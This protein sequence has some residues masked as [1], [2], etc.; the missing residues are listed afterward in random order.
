M[1][2]R[3]PR[4][5][6]T[7]RKRAFLETEHFEQ[8][9]KELSP[10]LHKVASKISRPYYIDNS[11]LVQEALWHIFR[12]RDKYDER[13]SSIMTWSLRVAKN[14]F[15]NIA[16]NGFRD[17]RCPKDSDKKALNPIDYEDLLYVVD[18]GMP[19]CVTHSTVIEDIHE[20][21]LIEHARKR[22][23]GFAATLFE[24]YID[25]PSKLTRLAEQRAAQQRS[26]VRHVNRQSKSMAK[27][28]KEPFAF[29]IDNKTISIYFNI[30]IHKVVKAKDAIHGALR[31]ASLAC[32]GEWPQTRS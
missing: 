28:C 4:P 18:G 10:V 12:N 24:A 23:R 15:M 29:H 20:Q 31:K 26:R 25:P 8:V 17:K 21:E 13:L 7:Q 6:C 19:N 9:A 14:K 5:K 27:S 1:I 16:A 30:P 2:Q 3:H 11:D 32:G 22:L